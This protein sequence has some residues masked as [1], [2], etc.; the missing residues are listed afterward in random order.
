MI[1]VHKDVHLAFRMKQNLTKHFAHVI[2]LNPYN[3]QVRLQYFHLTYDNTDRENL[4]SLP[5]YT[6]LINRQQME[7]FACRTLSK[8]G[9]TLYT[10]VF[11][12]FDIT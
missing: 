7:I 4:N 2:S 3:P 9:H 5:K 6:E 10:A 11:L 12:M 8:K 1:N